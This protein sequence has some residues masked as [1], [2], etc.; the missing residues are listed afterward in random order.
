L[1]YGVDNASAV[2][3]HGR[4]IAALAAAAAALALAG[5]FF[6][7]SDGLAGPG[8]L[9]ARFLGPSMIRAEIVVKVDGEVVSYRLDRGRIRAV[10]GSSLVLWER[11]RTLV[12]VPIAP[13]AQIL[14]NDQPVPAGALR[15]GMQALTVRRGDEPAQA[16]YAF[17]RR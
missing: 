17:A 13:G 4:T 5:V 1:T 14:L 12:V 10:R 6:P 3:K 15:R 7:T 16:V 9:V 2:L 11:D 8:S